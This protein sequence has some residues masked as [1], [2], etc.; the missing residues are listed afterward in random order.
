MKFNSA[1][2]MKNRC[3]LHGVLCIEFAVENG[4]KNTIGS[5]KPIIMDS[6]MNIQLVSAKYF[7]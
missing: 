1:N 3:L 2:C 5:E 4:L 7:F 6:E